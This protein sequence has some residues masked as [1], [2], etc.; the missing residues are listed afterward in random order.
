MNLPVKDADCYL[1][2]KPATT[3]DHIPPR[4]M[5]PKPRPNNLVTVPACYDCNNKTKLDDEYFRLV[6]AATSGDSPQSINLA[7]QRILPRVSDTPGLMAN[8]LG[9][10]QWEDF[11]SKG[12]IYLGRQPWCS[13]ERPRIQIIIDKIIRGLFLFHTGQRLPN[14]FV[15]D[16]FVHNPEFEE[17][18]QR[19][20]V[21]LPLY[22]IGDGSVFSYRYGRLNDS[23][24]FE[25]GWFLMFYDD[26]SFFVA[27]TV[28]RKPD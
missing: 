24:Q 11:Y 20:I 7:K 2:G 19:A 6:V 28:P 27:R 12:G 23:C 10:V 16:D 14:S 25:T 5:F 4:G 18:S 13:Y 15:V 3:S 8:F 21:S 22:R 26:S 1:C 9:N 17:A